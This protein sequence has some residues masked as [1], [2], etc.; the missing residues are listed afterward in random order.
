MWR[1]HEGM[2]WWMVFGGVWMVLLWAG[3]IALIVWAINRLVGRAGTDERPPERRD[4]IE[5][6]K[7]RYARGEITKEEFDEIK[8][9]L[10]VH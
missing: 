5:I 4:S 7:E 10:T 6:A 2:G 9:N 1:W 8:K 3:I